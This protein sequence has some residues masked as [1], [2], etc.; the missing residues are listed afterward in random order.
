MGD[1]ISLTVK[2]RLCTGCGVCKDA[3]PS[4]AITIVSGI[5]SFEPQVDANKCL[6]NKGCHRCM[7]IC[8]GLGVNISS[9]SKSLFEGDLIKK[10]PYVGRYLECFAGYSNDDDLRFHAASGGMVT[11]M[12]IWLLERNYIDGAIVTGFDNNQP[13]MN[14]SFLARTKDDILKAKSSKYAP[15][16]LFDMASEIKNDSGSRFVIVGLPCQIHAFR[17]FE[18]SDRKFKD[19]VIGYFGI[20]CSSTRTFGFTK[21]MF[22]KRGLSREGLSYFSYRDEGN[23]GGMVLDGVNPKSGEKY[24]FYEDY[25]HYNLPLRSFF[26]PRRCDF[27]IDHF[28]ELADVSFGDIYTQ[29]YCND[30]IGIN[31]LVIRS[32]IWNKYIMEAL[33][34]GVITLSPLDLE[35]LKKSQPMAYKKKTRNVSFI[36]LNKNIGRRVPIYDIEYKTSVSLYTFI[37]YIQNAAQHIIGKNK[38]LWW[39]IQYLKKSI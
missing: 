9:L 16:S 8:P 20:Y 11:Q 19:K 17:N 21:Y 35:T 39:I 23:L 37:D 31:S 28:A 36:Q 24:H 29:P 26:N 30:E 34:D 22:E 27:C 7:N 10:D 33:K 14:R 3:C 4:K 32:E 18:S 13:Y 12:L 15:V 1:N 25:R 6:C 2:N 5:D 38:S